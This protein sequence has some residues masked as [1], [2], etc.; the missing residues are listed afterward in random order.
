ML[1]FH[2]AMIYLTI[3]FFYEYAC[4]RYAL[5]GHV[6][7]SGLSYLVSLFTCHQLVYLCV[8][9]SVSC[10]FL[11]VQMCLST[12]T[13]TF[14]AYA[15]LLSFRRLVFMLTITDY[16]YSLESVDSSLD[17]SRDLFSFYKHL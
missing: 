14:L 5:S 13:L 8:P 10:A 11:L 2:H 15:C 3:V 17:S 9:L 1:R 12:R 7:F 6:T 16:G 4:G